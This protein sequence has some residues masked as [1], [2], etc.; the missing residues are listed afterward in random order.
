MASPFPDLDALT[1]RVGETLSEAWAAVV[2]PRRDAVTDAEI[3]AKAAGTAPVV[4]L[5]GKVQSGKSSIVRALTGAS[6]AEIGNGFKACTATARVFDFPAD[7]P[8]IRF[9]DTRGLGE[10]SYDPAADIAVAQEQAHLLLVVMKAADAAQDSVIAVAK[11]ARERHPDW[12][13]LVAQTCLHEGY[14]P[15]ARHPLPYPF[16]AAGVPTAS[17]PGD[18]TRTLA[19]QRERLSALPGTGAIRF[20][21]LDFT[22]EGDGFEPRLYGLD[23]LRAA[24]AAIAPDAIGGALAL[25]EI[26]SARQRRAEQHVMGYASAAAAADVVPVAGAVA[27]PA[28][29][30]KM[31]H[32]LGEIYA[33]TWDRRMVGEL[34]GALGAGVLTRIATGFGARQLTKLVPVWGQTAGAAAAAAMSFAA[35]FA[36]GKAAI[37]Y[38]ERKS[39]GGSGVEGVRQAYEEGL[40]I[41]LGLAQKRLPAPASRKRSDGEGP[42]S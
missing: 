2:S 41:A 9:L 18:L 27:V 12:P 8:A 26:A 31:L 38:L 40:K 32:S 20:V 22:Q 7:A 34:A 15:G 17:L 10:A 23:E 1:R 4:W 3:A 35:T 39:G 11:A 36:L 6:A 5:L 30:A 14:A 19:W 33:V 42:A 28:V 24:L 37:V 13:V 29:Q 25:G 16:D 21:P